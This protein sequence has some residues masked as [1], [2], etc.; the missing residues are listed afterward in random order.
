M[1]TLGQPEIFLQAKDDLFD[2]DGNIGP[3]SKDFLQGWMNK[4]MAWVK[5]HQ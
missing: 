5:K 4:Y 2:K 3:S 1:P